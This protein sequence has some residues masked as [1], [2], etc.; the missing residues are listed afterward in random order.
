[1]SKKVLFILHIPPPVHGSSM[2]GKFIKDSFLINNTFNTSYIY[3]GTSKTINEI[4]KNPLGK[5]NGYVSIVYKTLQQLLTNKPVMVYLAINARG[6][7]FY[8]DVVIALLVKLF[9]IQLVLHF[10]SK[11]VALNQDQFIDNLLYKW[12]F[13]NTKVILL[14]KYLYADIKKYVNNS[15]VYYCSNGIPKLNDTIRKEK[16]KNSVVQLLFL[17]NLI[18][19]KGVIV[20]LESLQILMNKGLNFQCNFV[21]GEGDISASAFNDK[22]NSLKLEA[23]VSYLGKKYDAEKIAIF[24]NSYI[25]ILP[26]FYEKECFPLVLLEASQFSLPLVST[27]EGAIPDIIED[28]VNGFLVQPKDSMALADKLEL[29][30]KDETLRASLGSAAFKKFNKEYTLGKFEKNLCSI[31]KS[32]N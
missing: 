19:S 32:I 6:I 16:N 25:F 24:K 11:G 27:F 22:V 26:T 17:S 8:K 4:G 18:K 29:L 30:I 5:I 13:K 20:L 12:V 28:G 15:N 3:L 9:G 10:H 7:G 1:M 23:Y 14:S 31:L 21:G 2:V